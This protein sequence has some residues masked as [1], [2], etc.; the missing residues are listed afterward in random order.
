MLKAE[1]TYHAVRALS[2]VQPRD[3]VA[4][5]VDRRKRN[6]SHMMKNDNVNEAVAFLSSTSHFRNLQFA[7]QVK[8]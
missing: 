7:F 3:K 1:K 8:L 4:K 2:E 5:S 6:V